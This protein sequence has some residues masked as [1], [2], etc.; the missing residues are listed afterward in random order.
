MKLDKDYVYYSIVEVLWRIVRAILNLVSF[1]LF[2]FFIFII[3]LILVPVYA[4]AG[5]ILSILFPI[6]VILNFSS[7]KKSRIEKSEKLTRWVNSYLEFYSDKLEYLPLDKINSII[8]KNRQKKRHARIISQ[9]SFKN[10]GFDEAHTLH[11][12]KSIDE[13]SKIGKG[14]SRD[15]KSKMLQGQPKADSRHSNIYEGSDRAKVQFDHIKK[16]AMNIDWKE[17]NDGRIEIG[18]IGE[19]IALTYEKKK[20]GKYGLSSMIEHVSKTQGDGLGYDI[21]SVDLN[22]NP[23]YIEVKATTGDKDSTF[24]MSANERKAMDQ[25]GD[26]YWL[27]RVYSLDLDKK[28]GTIIPIRGKEEIEN[29]F[30][31]RSFNYRLKPKR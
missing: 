23:V 30:R 21:K 4:V 19:I 9:S 1:I 7:K 13:I 5:L 28:E 16:G 31:F 11:Q 12:N 27:Y 18:Q 3:A 29:R 8:E 26:K 2:P 25:Y 10:S 24:K 20:L 15:I 22:G 6:E 17:I 14:Q